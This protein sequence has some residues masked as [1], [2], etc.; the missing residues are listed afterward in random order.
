MMSAWQEV[1][2]RVSFG[3]A[4]RT[5]REKRPGPPA[6]RAKGPV[7]YRSLAHEAPRCAQIVGE[8]L[9]P[10]GLGC[11]SSVVFAIGHHGEQ[12]SPGIFGLTR[13]KALRRGGPKAR[14]AI[15]LWRTGAPQGAQ[16]VRTGLEPMAPSCDGAGT[17]P[18]CTPANNARLPI[19]W[20]AV[21]GPAPFRRGTARETEKLL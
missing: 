19:V 13:E 14:L 20:R 15:A 8:G 17:L 5:G 6:G 11:D 10:M 21:A 2:K 9:E 3:L 16:M 4:G 12:C 18:S 7:R 1:G